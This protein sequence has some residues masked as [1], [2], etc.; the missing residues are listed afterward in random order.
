MA[1]VHLNEPVEL[2]VINCGECAGT[3][4]IN[5]RYREQQYQKGGSWTC[6]YCKAGWGYSNNNENATLKKQLAEEKRRREFYE[7]NAASERSA[8]EATERRLIARKAANTRLRN[9]VKNGVCPCCTRTFQNLAAHMQSEHPKF[10][11]TDE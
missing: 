4:A 9:Q 11:P 1:L 10:Q 5:E 3:Y 8:R 7:H 6:P 2:T